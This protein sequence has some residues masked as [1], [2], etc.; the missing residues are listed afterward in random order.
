MGTSL[1]GIV[2]KLEDLSLDKTRTQTTQES[3]RTPGG[4]LGKDEFLQLLVCQMKNQD[5]LEPEKDTD[6]IAQLAQFSSLEQMQNLNETALNSQAFSLVGKYV[7]INTKSSNGNITEINGVVDYITMNNGKAQ[8]SVNGQ[9]YSM[10]DLVEVKDSYYA[11]Q[12]YLP[13]VEKTEG[14]YDRSNKKPVD[15]KIDLGEGEYAATSVAVVINGAYVD[16]QY[17]TYEDGVLSIWPGAFDNLEDGTYE[18]G[19][20]FDDPYGTSITDKVSIQVTESGIKDGEKTEDETADGENNGNPDGEAAE[21]VEG[22]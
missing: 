19:L 17:L 7:L 1:D 6:F 2:T 4:D 13:S 14:V 3:S 21:K 18:V 16:S 15:I 22:Q 5:P 11:I 9:L 10:D 12:E 20:Y 8:L